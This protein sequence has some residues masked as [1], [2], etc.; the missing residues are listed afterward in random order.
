MQNTILNKKIFSSL[1]V[2]IAVFLTSCLPDSETRQ[3][4]DIQ[5]GLELEG[6]ENNITLG[7]DSLNVENIRLVHGL[8]FFIRGTDT[9]P[10]QLQPGQFTF[11]AFTQNPQAILPINIFPEG[12]Y[13]QFDLKIKKVENVTP[14]IDP[15]FYTDK[16]SSMII[17][18]TYNGSSF[19]FKSGKNF[20]V[21]FP[22]QPNIHVPKFNERFIFIISA[23][24]GTWFVDGDNQRLFDPSDSENAVEI[25]TNISNSFKCN[26]IQPQEAPC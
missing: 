24:I 10:V 5:V 23:D 16:N 18:G 6:F 4:S 11:S 2:L 15:E 9:L 25:N 22:F 8:S 7:D 13:T 1:I 14:N 20:S 19:T 12:T 17:E 26:Q 3:P 21:P